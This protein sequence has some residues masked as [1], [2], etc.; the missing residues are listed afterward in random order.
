[1]QLLNI[2]TSEIRINRNTTAGSILLVVI[3]VFSALSAV[4]SSAEPAPKS[5]FDGKSFAGWQGVGGDMANWEARDGILSWNGGPG[6]RW[7]ATDETFDDFELELEFKY[8]AGANSGIFYRTPLTKGRPAYEGNE[9]QIVDE[10][11]A[12]FAEKLTEDRRMGALYTVQPPSQKVQAPP[13]QWHR[14]DIRC[15]GTRLVVSL[16][17]IAVIDTILS[18]YPAA[19]LKEHPGLLRRSGHIGLQSKPDSQIKFRNI[20]IKVASASSR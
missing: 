17:G 19:L 12:G 14:L 2:S 9:I 6:A 16:K 10:S 4:K 20:K 18:E 3:S 1:M 15:V 11:A 8:A 5:L 13:G 7:I